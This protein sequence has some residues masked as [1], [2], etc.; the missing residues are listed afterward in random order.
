[1]YLG[2]H[3]LGAPRVATGFLSGLLFL[4]LY[5][6]YETNFDRFVTPDRICDRLL[7]CTI[8]GFTTRRLTGRRVVGAFLRT[9]VILIMANFFLHD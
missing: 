7:V 4:I 5:L 2:A 6:G 8:L 9:T 3:G 1:V